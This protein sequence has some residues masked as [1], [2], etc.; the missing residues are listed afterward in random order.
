ME[1]DSDCRTLREGMIGIVSEPPACPLPPRGI[2]SRAAVRNTQ[3]ILTKR[4]H[5]PPQPGA[6]EAEFPTRWI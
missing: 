4:L 6:K 3:G 1:N 5:L 2:F